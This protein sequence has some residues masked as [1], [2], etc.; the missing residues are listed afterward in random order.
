MSLFIYL[1]KLDV[2]RRFE[3]DVGAGRVEVVV[4]ADLASEAAQLDRL[5]KLVV[6]LLRGRHH[7]WIVENVIKIEN[8]FVLQNFQKKLN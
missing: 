6:K 4:I 7:L 3:E 1:Q 5:A 2:I 8:F